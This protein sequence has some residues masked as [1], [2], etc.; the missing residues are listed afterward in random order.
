[1]NTAALSLP[2]NILGFWTR[3]IRT[4]MH[5]SQE[6]LAASANLTPRTIQRI[7]AGEPSSIATRRSLARGLGYENPDI[8]EDPEFIASVLKLLDGAHSQKVEDFHKQFP[9]LVPIDA[10]PVK[11][12]EAL[13]S[14]AG[15]SEA[16]LF[17]CDDEISLEAKQLAACLFDYLRDLVDVWDDI[18]FS[19]RL[20]YTQDM[21]HMLSELGALDV[22]V[23]VASRSTK[24]VG[25]HWEN[26]TPLPLSIGY[27]VV[28]PKHKDIT[29][30]M[31]PKRL[32]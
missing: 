10:T 23:H 5:W 29:Q 31:V 1:M 17:H 19:D 26:K 18:S 3:C 14:L 16:Y 4:T 15:N 28:A 24:M 32:S 25:V 6:A 20:R 2:S 12:G 11:S 22:R 9:D 27:L 30:L 13:A 21:E 8:F 7:E